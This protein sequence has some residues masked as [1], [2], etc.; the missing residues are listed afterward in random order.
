RLDLLGG[1]ID[2]QGGGARRV[3]RQALQVGGGDARGGERDGEL[4]ER[5]PFERAPGDGEQLEGGGDVGDEFRADA[6]IVE[7]EGGQ[8]GHLR[9]RGADG[10]G[11]RGGGTAGHARR[12]QGPG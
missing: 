11:V 4:G 7:Q 6:V 1:R 3:G 9:E 5:R 10:D 12:P 2:A 8:L